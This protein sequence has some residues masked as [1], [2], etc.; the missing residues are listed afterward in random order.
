MITGGSAGDHGRFASQKPSFLRFR[1]SANNDP[2]GRR[3]TQFRSSWDTLHPGRAWAEKLVRPAG[4]PFRLQHMGQDFLRGVLASSGIRASARND[5]RFRP[6]HRR[7][8]RRAYCQAQDGIAGSRSHTLNRRKTSQ[9]R[10]RRRLL[11]AA[12]D[13]IALGLCLAHVLQP[14]EID[15][16]ARRPRAAAARFAFQPREKAHDP[17]QVQEGSDGRE[18]PGNVVKHAE[19]SFANKKPARGG[20]GC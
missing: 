7:R 16:Q 6:L 4:S 8:N 15:H 9:F 18:Q 13:L 17:N 2:G 10:G 20:P 3:A 12:F 11:V 19:L 14:A 5:R 1:I